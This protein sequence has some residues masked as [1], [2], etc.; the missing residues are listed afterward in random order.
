MSICAKRV[1]RY[2]QVLVDLCQC[3]GIVFPQPYA[4]PHLGWCV[5]TFCSLHVQVAA[6]IV[7]PNGGI[8]AVG[9]WAGRPIA[10]ASHIVFISA[11]ILCFC[12]GLEAAVTM[13][14]DLSRGLIDDCGMRRQHIPCFSFVNRPHAPATRLRRAACVG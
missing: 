7:L 5:C 6:T 8:A 10:Q 11:K 4:L 2:L 9:E 1:T 3:L 14:N 13:G 12:F